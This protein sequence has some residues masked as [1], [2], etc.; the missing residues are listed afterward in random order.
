M[1]RDTGGGLHGLWL[2]ADIRQGA[3][4]DQVSAR[5]LKTELLSDNASMTKLNEVPLHLPE[6]AVLADLASVTHDFHKAVIYAQRVGDLMASDFT[7]P[8]FAFIEPLS[9][10]ALVRYRRPFTG[11]MRPGWMHKECVSTFTPAQVE[12]HEHLLLICNQHFA[13]A[14]N[15]MERP[16]VIGYFQGEQLE[17]A[18]DVFSIG[19]QVNSAV[20]LSAPEARSLSRLAHACLTFI[21]DQVA[22][23]TA[24]LL[25]L[26][27]SLPL[28][29]LRQWSTPVASVGN[30]SFTKEKRKWPSYVP[31]KAE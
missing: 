11:G 5:T 6:A 29:T 17:R 12:E 31:P 14:V 9:V 20:S 27:H 19:T 24:R 2:G 16:A 30:A 1:R 15:A 10:T 25:P 22:V 7:S 13:H 28:E 4:E 23:E 18:Q 21:R 3:R 8:D 26:V